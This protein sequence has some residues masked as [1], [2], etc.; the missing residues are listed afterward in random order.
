MGLAVQRSKACTPNPRAMWLDFAGCETKRKRSSS[1]KR[2]FDMLWPRWQT[3]CLV[4]PS[5]DLFIL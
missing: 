4:D 1:G 5:Y 3:R 2:G